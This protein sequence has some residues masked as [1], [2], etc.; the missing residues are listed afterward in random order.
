MNKHLQYGAYVLRHK[1]FV[2]VECFKAG[3][4]W[5]G[6]VHDLSKFLPQEW[7]P[8]VE[9]FYG[10]Y[11]KNQPDHVKQTFDR[12]WLHH[13]K[14]NDHHWQWWVLPKDEGSLKPLPMGRQA[15][16][17]MLCDW[18]GAGAAQGN[19]G[20]WL[21]VREWYEKNKDK[22]TLHPE[23]RR[24]VRMLINYMARRQEKR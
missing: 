19:K 12:A 10:G 6:L 2:A 16:L 11:G 20:G 24:T 18:K 1:Y 17:E 23:T 13:Q 4:I 22:M 15:L 5:R 9:S 7:F 14:C 8:Y 21:E 3:L